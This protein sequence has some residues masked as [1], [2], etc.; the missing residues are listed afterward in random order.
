MAAGRKTGGRTRGTPNKATSRK[1]EA[2]ETAASLIEDAIPEAFK[3][4][5]HDYLIA[6]YKDT[7]NEQGI[8]VAAAKAALPYEKPRLASVEHTGKDGGPIETTT[9]N[10][11]LSR[12]ILAILSEAKTE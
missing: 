8:R 4:A 10:R 9:D 2:R 5:A 12:A 6:V 1:K 7:R 3:G 11:S